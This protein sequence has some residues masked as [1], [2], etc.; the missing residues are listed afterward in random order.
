[1]YGQ[2]GLLQEAKAQNPHD[3]RYLWVYATAKEELASML[4]RLPNVDLF[5]GT[6]NIHRL[7]ELLSR[8]RTTSERVV[9]IWDDAGEPVEGLPA[10]RQSSFK[11]WVT[12]M[13]GCNNFCSYCIVP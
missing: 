2:V 12:I 10:L 5:F 13:H 11:A 7:P 3:Y 9:E 4:E 1:M 8:A 6:H